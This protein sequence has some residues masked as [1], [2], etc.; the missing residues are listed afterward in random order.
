[1]T[2]Q[3]YFDESG[4]QS[5]DPVLVL[6][7]LLAPAE[8]WESLSVEWQRLIDD[9]GIQ[10][11]HMSEFE[12][13]QGPYKTWRNEGV[14]EIRLNALLDLI[15]NHAKAYVSIAVSE[16]RFRQVYGADVKSNLKYAIA[17]RTLFSSI[18]TLDR[19]GRRL[20]EYGL[21]VERIAFF[22][23]SGARGIG[24]VE[25]IFNR[26]YNQ[27]LH[28]WLFRLVDFTFGGKKDYPPLQAAD[29]VAYEAFK[30]WIWQ[31]NSDHSR[32]HRYPWRRLS[33]LPSITG[34]VSVADLEIWKPDFLQAIAQGKL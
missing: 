2:L 22:F 30:H 14:R 15:C 24:N 34:H 32:P 9:W 26:Y 12:N 7:G 8:N 21:D 17:A 28:R 33:V 29:I 1:V 25:R 27:P 19:D 13:N 6:A 3:A 31:F 11:F 23:E 18:S 4:T 5:D 20:S 16:E 10:F